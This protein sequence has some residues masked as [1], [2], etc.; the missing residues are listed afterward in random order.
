MTIHGACPRFLST[1]RALDWRMPSKEP[2]RMYSSS[3]LCSAGLS[4]PLCAFSES[5]FIRSCCAVSKWKCSSLRDVSSPI[6]WTSSLASCSRTAVSAKSSFAA[7]V[8]VAMRLRTHHRSRNDLK[9][10]STDVGPLTRGQ[11]GE[12]TQFRQ[13]RPTLTFPCAFRGS[14]Q[15]QVGCRIFDHVTHGFPP[16]R[17][18]TGLLHNLLIISLPVRLFTL[19]N[20]PMA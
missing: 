14:D 4:A 1:C 5:T 10:Y 8:L 16:S 20:I 7:L 11:R 12:R 15:R 17:L 2:T 9:H 6:L 18:G 19:N 3:S 13:P